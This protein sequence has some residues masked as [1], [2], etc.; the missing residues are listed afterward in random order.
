MRVWCSRQVMTGLLAVAG[1]SLAAQRPPELIGPLPGG[2]ALVPTG[3]RVTPAGEAHVISNDRPKDLILAPDGKRLAVLCARRVIVYDADLARSTFL[4][5][6]GGP[7]GIA[8]H[9]DGQRLYFSS[10]S[11]LV[12][13]AVSASA[14]SVQREIPLEE[15]GSR[16]PGLPSD[17]QAA[18]IAVSKDGRTAWVAL[19][20]RNA[21]AVVD[22]AAA[23]LS[24][25][26]PVGVCPYHVALSPDGRTL[27]V[28]NRGGPRT[29]AGRGTALSAGTPVK[30]ERTTDAALRG[31]VTIL[32]VAKGTA[33]EVAVG[34][35]P[36]GTAFRSD[37]SLAYV[38]NSDDDTI[39]ILDITRARVVH[40]VRVGSP[41]D[42]GFG[43]MPTD[44]A[45]SDD[46]RTLYA[47]CGG[48][49]AVAVIPLREDGR[50][51]AKQ[52]SGYI[53]TAWFPVNVEARG[54]ALWVACAK[55]IGSRGDKRSGGFYVHSSV[56]VVER[57]DPREAALAD[58]SAQ[59]AANN[60]WGEQLR[61]R[62]GL[63]AV[64]VPER[65]GEPS[66]FKH[67]IYI[68]KENHTYDLDLG[69]MPE[70]NGD[71]KLCLF[72][73]D[74]TPNEHALAREFV[75]LD[76]TYTS[77][78]NSADGH[79]WTSAALCNAYMEQNYSSYARSYPYDGG[80]ALAYS[81][82]GFLWTAA[83]HRGLDV[84]VFG[85]FVNR[86][87][88]VDT[89]DPKRRG[90][91]S[92]T[93]LWQ[94]YRTGAGR[95][96]I[97]AETDNAA[98]RPFLHPNYIGFPQIVSDQWR[99]DRF[100]ADLRGWERAGRMPHL[101]ILLLPNNHTSGTSPGM[102]TPR[103]AVADNDLA[104]GRIVDAVSH[105]RFW[106]DTLI[107]CI[108]DD[109]QLGVDH[110]DGHRTAA[111]CVSPYTRRGAVVGELY[112]HVGLVR[113][114]GLVLG[115]PA[116]NRFDQA[117]RPMRECFQRTADLRPYTH[118]S[119]RVRLDEMNK[120]ASALRGEAR[121][122]AQA[123]ARLDWS[124]VDRADPSTVARAVWIAQ[125]PGVRFPVAAF[126]PPDD[127][128]D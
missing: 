98:L 65:L 48:T 62:R 86:P 24:T 89:Q 53:P 47:T 13:V 84:R 93:E 56:G 15:A 81:P 18:G 117:G 33:R 121:W 23:R 3:Q 22:L 36:A 92:W 39:S 104:L 109:S 20:T 29:P 80:D 106:P 21:L 17:P 41:L 50:S 85:E 119:N 101:C 79:Q 83:A 71:P 49:N 111:F 60:G 128:H 67:V 4:E 72:G 68:I 82:K 96:R 57:I 11:K 2:G 66:V 75:L 100:I 6:G 63:A 61:P 108:E 126:H 30:I 38:T 26:L 54:D 88:I 31:S 114:I 115:I 55:G 14:L 102:P 19:G 12:E 113:T 69:D 110:V 112:T 40:T 37:G 73:E 28:S 77:G 64:P 59:V 123:S 25:T 43:H 44:V 74:V 76:N 32:D 105:S 91:P 94:D 118:R 45:L 46:Q 127:D 116:M 78:T 52:P 42:G 125:G 70:G 1:V 35:Q 120:P 103:A 107:L 97:L 5:R 58:W 7:L 124:D 122:L 27:C 34:R 10:G 95:Y 16:A 8:W 87:R 9:P 99:A 51:E 90:R